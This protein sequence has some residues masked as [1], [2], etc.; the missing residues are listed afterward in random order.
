[1]DL[2]EKFMAAGRPLANPE[3]ELRRQQALAHFREMAESHQVPAELANLAVK[4]ASGRYR[5][6][7]YLIV[8]GEE[9][10]VTGSCTEN[11]DAQDAHDRNLICQGQHEKTFLISSKSDDDEGK[12]LRKRSMWMVL[13]GAAASVICL[14]LLLVHLH[15][16]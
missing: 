2:I 1:M 15:L 3:Q 12:T 9:Y 7:E 8:P 13:G 10:S 14:A 16:F 11:T 5:L 4:G 6:R